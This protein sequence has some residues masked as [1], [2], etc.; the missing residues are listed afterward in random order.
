MKFHPIADIFPM[1][2]SEYQELKEDIQKDGLMEPIWKCIAID[3]NKE[4]VE[5]IRGRIAK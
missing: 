3:R 5:I 4:F 2:K 1:S